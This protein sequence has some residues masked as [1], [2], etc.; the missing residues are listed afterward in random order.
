MKQVNPPSPT[1]YAELLAELKGRIRTA[2]IRAGLAVNHELVM[3]YWRIGRDILIRQHDLGWG[4]GA[5]KQL[6]G[7]LRRE[8]PGLKGL[9]PRNLEYMKQLAESWPDGTIVPQLVAQIP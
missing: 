7:D 9:S 6:A 3:L 8:F 5:I 2:Q 4:A 1:G